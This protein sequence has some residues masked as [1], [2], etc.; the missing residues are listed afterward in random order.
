[1]SI[2]NEIYTN[3]RIKFL[4]ENYKT[5]HDF[6]KELTLEKCFES[7]LK[8]AKDLKFEN[9]VDLNKYNIEIH[10]I[11]YDYYSEKNK[12]V[13]PNNQIKIKNIDQINHLLNELEEEYNLI[14]LE[15]SYIDGEFSKELVSSFH[16]KVSVNSCLNRKENMIEYYTKI[17]YEVINIL[18]ENRNK[19]ILIVTNSEVIT[20]VKCIINGFPYLDKLKISPQKEKIV[21]LK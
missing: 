7:I 2:I 11:K 12:E 6:V 17:I 16:T 19:K 3:E 4:Y 10:L 18:E 14:I 1:M 21:K 20:I 5:K 13:Y 15:D 9:K 8:I